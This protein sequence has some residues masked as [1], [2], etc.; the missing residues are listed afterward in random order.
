MAH[1]APPSMGFSR[2][3]YSSGVPLPSPNSN[4]RELIF[5]VYFSIDINTI[6]DFTLNI[7]VMILLCKSGLND[8]QNYQSKH[9][10]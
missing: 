5:Q 4:A 10:F 1:Q 8:F 3:E 7:S 6:N 2:Q 9:P